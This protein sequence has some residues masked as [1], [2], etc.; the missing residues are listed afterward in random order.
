MGALGASVEEKQ[1][2]KQKVE[3]SLQQ[4]WRE[5]ELG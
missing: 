4:L 2:G 1:L 5:R 3:L